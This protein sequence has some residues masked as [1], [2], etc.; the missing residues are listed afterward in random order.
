MTINHLVNHLVLGCCLAAPAYADHAAYATHVL[1]AWQTENPQ[2]ILHGPDANNGAAKVKGVKPFIGGGFI[3]VGFSSPVH[4]DYGVDIELRHTNGGVYDV[5]AL[6]PDTYD[7]VFLGRGSGHGYFD[8]GY[9]P[10]TTQ[11]RIENVGLMKNIFV[12]W[13]RNRH[14]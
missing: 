6:D 14:P 3:E 4:N 12:D 5:F 7:W 13:V 8:L 1:H 2:G 10:F 11:L 9:L